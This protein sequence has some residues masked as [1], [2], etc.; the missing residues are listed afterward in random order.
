MNLLKKYDII[1]Q[2]KEIALYINI[3]KKIIKSLNKQSLCNKLENRLFYYS[4]S[5][6]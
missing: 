5:K 2:N 1:H 4:F 3:I 6:Y